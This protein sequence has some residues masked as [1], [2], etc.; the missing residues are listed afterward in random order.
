MG[1]QQRA[2]R[3]GHPPRA[4]ILEL[5]DGVA[6]RALEHKRDPD[7][8]QAGRELAHGVGVGCERRAAAL[9]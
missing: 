4:P 9:T 1:G 5:V 3:L 2:E 8:R 6:Q 7:I